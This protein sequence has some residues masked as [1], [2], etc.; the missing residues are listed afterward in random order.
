MS[1]PS[2]SLIVHGGARTIPPERKADNRRGCLVAVECG[3]AILRAGGT[4]LDAA[5]A[6]VRSLENDPAF[7]AGTG[8]V[9]TSSGHIEMDAAIMDGTTLDVGAVAAMRCVTNPVTVARLLLR[10]GPVLLV[11]EGAAAFAAEQGIGAADVLA[12]AA[13]DEPQCDT[14]GCVA[15]DI[16]GNIAVATSTGGLRGQ[17][18]GRVGDAPI[19]GSGFYAD[20]LLG[21]VA[22]SGDGESIL[23]VCLAARV[24]QHLA[25]VA[26]ARAVATAL[27]ELTRVGGEAGIIALD[28]NGRFGFVHN[29]EHFAFALAAS[30]L[31]HPQAAI[32]QTELKGY[33]CDT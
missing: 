24:I 2:W 16:E 4:A 32:H 18:L 3:A 22:I 21:G 10:E 5:E 26:P 1:E 8:S 17:R 27:N 25:N 31:D 13:D 28:R 9:P 7:N 33:A 14:V 30:W 12:T 15:R 20:N 6:A 23:R 29:S 11:G 19:P